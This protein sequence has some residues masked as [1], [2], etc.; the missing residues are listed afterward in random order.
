MRAEQAAPSHYTGDKSEYVRAMFAGIAHRYDLLNSVLS[1]TRHK[2]WRRTAVRLA[3]PNLGDTV[4]DVCT[5]TGDFAFDLLRSV[6][7][8]GYVVGSDF[9]APMVSIGKQKADARGHGQVGMMVADTLRLPYPANT[10][11]CATV[12][13]GIRNVADVQQAFREM[14]RVVRPGGRVACLEFNRPTNP[15]WRPVVGLYERHVLPRI[16]GLLSRKEAYEYLQASIQ[17]FHSRE[18]LTEMMK[19]AGLGNIRLKDLNLGSVCIHVG[20]KL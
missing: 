2:A 8:G 9:C 19:L 3:A 20:S 1:F 5:G 11:D 7:P 4:L 12:G 16:A 13:F 17:A 14:A 15:V 10:F 18:E 6:G